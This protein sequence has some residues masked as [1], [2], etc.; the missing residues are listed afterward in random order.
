M[1]F[2][3]Y[4][5]ECGWYHKIVWN[6]QELLD[7]IQNTNGREN[8]FC[9][10][11]SFK[12]MKEN[13]KCDHKSAVID[14]MYFD[15]D[16]SEGYEQLL[17]L[18]EYFKDYKRCAMFTGRYYDLIVKLDKEYFGSDTLAYNQRKVL[19]E[20]GVRLEDTTGIG[21]LARLIRIYDTWN[22]RGLFCITLN[23]DDIEK[24]PRHI[25]EL[26]RRQ[27]GFRIMGNV[28]YPMFEIQSREEEE[29]EEIDLTYDVVD[30]YIIPPCLLKALNNPKANHIERLALVQYLSEIMRDGI[31]IKSLKKASKDV[32]V[33]EIYSFLVKNNKW[34]NF[35]KVRTKYQLQNIVYEYEY[36]PSCETLI[37]LGICV[38]KCWRRR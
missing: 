13:Q 33:E 12:G 16:G 29:I 38:G 11:Y 10:L 34:K 30:T 7:Y 20:T 31:P 14:R 3:K 26:A 8:C 15:L 1:F 9:S 25:E 36:S 23:E 27:Q 35:N 2:D 21:N 32:L 22:P 5:R 28:P 6:D 17:I 24:G 4:P 18:N 19:R 37:S